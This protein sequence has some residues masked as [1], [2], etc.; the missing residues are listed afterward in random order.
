MEEIE[1]TR[2]EVYFGE[3]SNEYVVVGTD[4]AEFD[5]PSGDS[6]EYTYYE[7]TAGIKLNLFNI[8]LLLIDTSKFSIFSI[9]SLISL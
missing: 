4:E 8:F 5:Y 9:L 2:P 6:N 7:G 3:L 1:I